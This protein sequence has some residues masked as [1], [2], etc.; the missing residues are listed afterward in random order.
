[1]SHLLHRFTRHTDDAAA[2][3]NIERALRDLDQ[4][5]HIIRKAAA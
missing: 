2:T 5:I 1:M 3:R 4:A